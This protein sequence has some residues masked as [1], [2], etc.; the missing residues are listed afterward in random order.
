VSEPKPGDSNRSRTYYALADQI[1]LEVS[2][3][4]R[5]EAGPHEA[6][7]VAVDLHA[8]LSTFLDSAIVGYFKLRDI[9]RTAFQ[10]ETGIP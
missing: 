4:L 6:L 1:A 3:G 9:P 10:S 2:F 8:A 7:K 5:K